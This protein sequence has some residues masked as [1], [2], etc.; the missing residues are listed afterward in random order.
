MQPNPTIH[1]PVP[2]PAGLCGVPKAPGSRPASGPQP[3]ARR[4]LG[5]ATLRACGPARPDRPAAG[6]R[7]WPWLLASAALHGL[8][9]AALV[10]CAVVAGPA[11]EPPLAV[12][13]HVDLGELGGLGDGIPAGGDGLAGGLDGAAR[14][15]AEALPAAA[16]APDPE[17]V[18][19]A[20]PGPPA[21]PTPQPVS[22][23]LAAPGPAPAPRTPPSRPRA[24]PKA[25]PK[26]PAPRPQPPGPP[27]AQPGTAEAD[28]VSATGTGSGARAG[29]G[30][31][32]GLAGEGP[33]KGPT[34]GAGPGGSGEGRGDGGLS[35]GEF[36]RG[37]GPRFRHR[38]PL[39]YP[40]GAKRAGQEGKVR[41]RLDIDAE[42]VL[43]NVSVVEH[44]GLEFVEEALR[45]IKAST[46]YPAMRQGRPEACHA[47]LTI[48]FA[49]G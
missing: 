46:Y 19:R 21:E 9:A 7:W 28:H 16:A 10:L 1:R 24:V 22:E 18:A 37:D 27:P 42:G 4:F 14:G 33:G 29:D 39:R 12:I 26:P 35:V 34:A 2:G 38:S 41:L 45:A 13:G 25:R 23:P 30:P 48:R 31:G 43:R 6:D 32:R 3:A 20:D 40:D 36:G 49:Q 5:A 8:A 44:T 15:T 17:T 11:P 47:L